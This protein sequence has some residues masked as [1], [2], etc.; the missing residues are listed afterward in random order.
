MNKIG[1]TDTDYKNA[2]TIIGCEIECIKAVDIVESKGQGFLPDGSIKI[3]FEP[4]IFWQRLKKHGISPLNKVAGNEDI[5]YPIWGSKPYG[6]YVEQ[7]DRLDKAKKI[8]ELA[9]LESASWGRFQMMGFNYREC[10]CVDVRELVKNMA[11]SES[12]HLL[13]FTKYIKHERLDDELV[14]KLWAAFAEGY[15]GP[16]YKRNNYDVNLEAAYTQVKNVN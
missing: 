9:A 15:N 5:L 4:H 3:L 1:L 16:S 12:M 11:I 10:G 7:H 2:A 8:H 6:K 14:A 13:L